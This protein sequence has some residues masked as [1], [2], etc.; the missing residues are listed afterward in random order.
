M[1]LCV[2]CRTREATQ[3]HHVSYEPVELKI[4]ICNPCHNVIHRKGT[5]PPK[6]PPAGVF[7]VRGVDPILW[8]VVKTRSV[9]EGK[10]MGQ[11]VNE[12]LVYWL[13]EHPYEL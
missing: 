10:K 7:A 5:G 6:M 1:V 12:A 4:D 9:L 3:T 13:A 2:V 11:S 8:R